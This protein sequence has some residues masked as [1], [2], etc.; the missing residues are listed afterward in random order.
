MI[1][2]RGYLRLRTYNPG[3]LVKYRIL[4]RTV[5]E[6]TTGYIGNMEIYTAED[7]KFEEIKFS[8]LEK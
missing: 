3:V 4:V 5:C 6:A 2:W 8:V 7:K 1:T